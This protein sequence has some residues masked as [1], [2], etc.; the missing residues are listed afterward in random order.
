[1]GKSADS[2]NRVGRRLRT[3]PSEGVLFG[4]A[5]VRKAVTAN[6]KRDAGSDRRLSG[7]GVRGVPQRVTVTRKDQGHISEGRI[8]AGPPKQRAPWFWM[9]E[10]TQRH[11][12][13]PGTKAKRTWSKAIDATLPAVERNFEK[14]YND[15]LNG[16]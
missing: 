8:M 14:L 13:H 15:A 2:L 3:L 5:Q 7:L 9:E 16:G 4:T 11:G 12:R 6:L 10:G 1:M